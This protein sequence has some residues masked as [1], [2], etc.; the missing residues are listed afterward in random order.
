MWVRGLHELIAAPRAVCTVLCTLKRVRHMSF[1]RQASVLSGSI[2]ED[3][4][5]WIG[6][7]D[8]EKLEFTSNGEHYHFPR[9]DHCEQIYCNIEG[10]ATFSSQQSLT[11]ALHC[12]QL[13][14]IAPA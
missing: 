10:D 9:S 12:I 3:S 8:K 7:F 11:V 13:Q 14:L 4:E 1:L 2:Q 6:E 5:V